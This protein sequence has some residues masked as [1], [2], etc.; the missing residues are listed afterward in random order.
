MAQ[1]PEFFGEVEH[2]HAV[3]FGAQTHTSGINMLTSCVLAVTPDVERHIA[4]K[5]PTRGRA[6][7]ITRV[8]PLVFVIGVR[9]HA[10]P[11]TG[12]HAPEETDT[13]FDVQ[14]DF[15]FRAIAS[16]LRKDGTPFENIVRV[17]AALRG[18]RYIPRYQ[19]GTHRHFGGRMPFAGYSIGTILGARCEHEI[20]A[21][22]VGRGERKE[23]WWS[24]A[25]STMADATRGGGLTFLRNCSGMRDEVKGMALRELQGR[26][27]E[28]V[29]QAVA[30][31]R[32][33]LRK[34]GTDLDSLLRLDVFVRDIY[35]EDEIVTAL[36]ATLGSAMP[37]INVIGSEPAHGAEL[38]LTAIAGGA[39]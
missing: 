2:G 15:C 8:G 33:L 24:A 3:S 1:W 36:K 16:H 39:G 37:V 20:G 13:S 31:V 18:A 29:K 10:D 7:R 26:G 14:L 23:I 34:T 27:P 11:D 5:Q 19:E 38:E 12:E 30:N 25:D 4:V 32:S 17:D 22:A 28:Q 21:V 6:S 35:A 9:G